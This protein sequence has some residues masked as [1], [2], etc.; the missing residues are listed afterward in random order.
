MGFYGHKMMTAQ[1]GNKTIIVVCLKVD[2][3]PEAIYM[4]WMGD[5][6][7]VTGLCKERWGEG[8][9]SRVNQVLYYWK[10]DD[11]KRD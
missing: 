9:L 3:D 8:I 6:D 11:A 5:L 4:E 1:R 7:T 2:R 10:C